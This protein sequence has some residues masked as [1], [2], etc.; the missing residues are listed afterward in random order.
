M[1]SGNKGEQSGEGGGG[2][3]GQMG[4]G[5]KEREM[6]KEGGETACQA[7]GWES[8]EVTASGSIAKEPGKIQD[9]PG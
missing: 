4:R 3:E 6:G 8:N 9:A 1:G 2:K 7:P 5:R